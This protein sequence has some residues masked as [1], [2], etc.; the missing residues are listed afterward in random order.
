MDTPPNSIYPDWLLRA[1]AFFFWAGLVTVIAAGLFSLSLAYAV[2]VDHTM[3]PDYAR[4]I[5]RF[6][7]VIFSVSLTVL[8]ACGIVKV[9]LRARHIEGV[10]T[11]VAILLLILLPLPAAVYYHF[12][13]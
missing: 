3:I 10:R 5:F 6:L 4:A 1:S 9:V 11:G 13:R 12:V 8:W 7:L 2:Q